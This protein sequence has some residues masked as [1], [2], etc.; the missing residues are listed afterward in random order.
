MR[1][2]ML[3]AAILVAAC[4]DDGHIVG[5]M[6]AGGS[7]QS[8][9]VTST[10]STSTSSQGSNS[11]SNDTTGGLDSN[12]STNG[13]TSASMSTGV[14]GGSTGGG[15]GGGSGGTATAGSD[16][17]TLGSGGASTTTT[18]GSTSTGDAGGGSTDGGGGTGGVQCPDGQ[19]WCPGCNPGE[20][21]CSAGGCPG[22][23]C[24]QCESVTSLEECEVTTGC[25][26]VFEDPGTCG[27]ATPGCCATYDFCAPGTEAICDAPA[28]CAGPVPFCEEPYVVSLPAAGGCWEG[29]VRQ[30]D[31][32][33]TS[34]SGN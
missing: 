8:E 4:G 15:A 22:V 24:P 32:R 10:S 13:S 18:G 31:C 33:A 17:S 27:C 2:W 21:T 9:N 14:G 28:A 26:P 6:A 23:A 3:G 25:H 7:S 20:G 1:Q 12:G 30:E 5:D 34:S 16:G 19:I 11:G 29:C